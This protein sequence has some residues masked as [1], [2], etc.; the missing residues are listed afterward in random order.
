MNFY[1][2]YRNITAFRLKWL[3][4]LRRGLTPPNQ[5]GNIIR[6]WQ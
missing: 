3:T 1:Y 6:N 2:S 5:S 4:F